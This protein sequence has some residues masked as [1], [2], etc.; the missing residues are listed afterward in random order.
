MEHEPVRNRP[1]AT[2]TKQSLI[3]ELLGL[4]APLRVPDPLRVVTKPLESTHQDTK[5]IVSLI[6]PVS[7]TTDNKSE[8]P[9]SEFSLE[10]TAVLPANPSQTT[11]FPAQPPAVDEDQRSI[12]DIPDRLQDPQVP[13]QD[14]PSHLSH[15]P[16]LHRSSSF[17]G[18]LA[19]GSSSS[20]AFSLIDYTKEVPKGCLNLCLIRERKGS[21]YVG[22]MKEHPTSAILEKQWVDKIRPHLTKDLIPVVN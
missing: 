7:A 4:K 13:P 11:E 12:V 21:K 1:I 16:V 19:P 22:L 20:S 18:P 6:S 9:P 14:T 10:V 15:S 5:G 17:A 2:E 3:K 8:T